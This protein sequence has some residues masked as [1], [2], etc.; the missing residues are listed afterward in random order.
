MSDIIKHLGTVENIEGAHIQVKIVQTSACSTCIAHKHCNSSESKDKIID[1]YDKEAASYHPGEE[2]YVYGTTTMGMKAVFWAFGV[3]FII[4]VIVLF[5]SMLLTNANEAL[6]ALLV[7]VSLATYYFILFR[8]KE[9]FGKK[10]RFTIKP[11]NK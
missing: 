10:F 1:I 4:L 8:H 3:P 11:I 7:L 2:V 9:H 6:A 5:G